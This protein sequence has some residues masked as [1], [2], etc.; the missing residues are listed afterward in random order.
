MIDMNKLYFSGNEFYDIHAVELEP[1]EI[2]VEYL[3]E[4]DATS[5]SANGSEC[6]YPII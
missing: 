5:I 4:R 3:G 1:I 6:F 2:G